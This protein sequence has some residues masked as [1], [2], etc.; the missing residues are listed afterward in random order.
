MINHTM[1]DLPEFY[2]AV[3]QALATAASAPSKEVDANTPEAELDAFLFGP[4]MTPKQITEAATAPPAATL[5][6]TDDITDEELS[7][8]IRGKR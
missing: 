5:R 3:M 2:E 7:A 6:I 8:F 1:T 4:T